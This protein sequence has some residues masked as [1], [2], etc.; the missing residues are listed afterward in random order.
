MIGVSKRCCP[1]CAYLIQHLGGFVIRGA[2]KTITGCS[3]PPW[4]PE[5]HKRVM[6][7]EFGKRLR[8][9]L[10]IL[11]FEEP[12]TDSQERVSSSSICLSVMSFDL[13]NQA[14]GSWAADLDLEE[15]KLD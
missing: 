13:E 8:E 1:V 9:A 15:N 5:E 14:A 12:E 10:D 11:L 4:L 7:E 3:L 6:V 2:H